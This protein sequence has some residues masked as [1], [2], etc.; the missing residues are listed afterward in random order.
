MLHLFAFDLTVAW[1]Y[2]DC[3][4]LV[5]K[6]VGNGAPIQFECS[7][8]G[9]P[10]IGPVTS[11]YVSAMAD[12]ENAKRASPMLKLTGALCS[13]QVPDFLEDSL[14]DPSREP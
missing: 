2:C 13:I 7:C 12:V 3:C 14:N 10:Q 1:L 11:Y 6:W 8:N 4:K 9:I 5:H